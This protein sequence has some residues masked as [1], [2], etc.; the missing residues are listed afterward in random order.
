MCETNKKKHTQTGISTSRGDASETCQ[1]KNLQVK[2]I[3]ITRD[4]K[5]L[6]QVS[7]KELLPS[8]AN[9]LSYLHNQSIPVAQESQ[10]SFQGQL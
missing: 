8:A 4:P 1:M 9:H 5:A 7:D 6:P 10:R 2:R 3:K